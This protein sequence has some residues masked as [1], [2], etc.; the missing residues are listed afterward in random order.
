M[1]E[2][3][4]VVLYSDSDQVQRA[5][6]QLSKQDV[7]PLDRISM[8][9]SAFGVGDDPIGVYHHSV[10]ERMR[11]WGKLGAIWGGLW[12]ALA[13]AAGLFLVPGLGPLLAAGPIVEVLAGGAAGAAL[14]G[15]AMAGAGALSHLS[16]ALHAQ[17]I[18]NAEIDRLHQAIAKGKYLM[19]AR[20]RADECP[21]VCEFLRGTSPEQI[22]QYPYRTVV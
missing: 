18:P 22:E 3:M 6:E 10:G 17:G 21:A 9:G 14:G 1:D 8:L 4:V 19:L 20:C 12:G 16:S 11:G 13:G 7:L 5:V 2:R 15:S